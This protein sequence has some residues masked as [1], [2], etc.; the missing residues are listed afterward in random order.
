MGKSSSGVTAGYV[1]LPEKELR[2]QGNSESSVLFRWCHGL[3]GPF[4]QFWVVELQLLDLV[5]GLPGPL[6]PL[7]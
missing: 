4:L 6:Q 3:G 1:R 2:T 7:W 5:R